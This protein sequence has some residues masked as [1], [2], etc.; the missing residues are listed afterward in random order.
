V[1]IKN[2]QVEAQRPWPDGMYVQG[3]GR[4]LVVVRA[5]GH[6]RT[7]FVEACPSSGGTFLRGEGPS[8][9]EAEDACWAKYQTVLNCADGLGVH[10]PF[11]AGRYESGAG[12]CT[13][14]GAWF[15]GMLEPSA[16]HQA[17]EL[18]AQTVAATWGEDI[19]VS[20][21]WCGLVA[22]ETARLLAVAADGTE[23]P[24]PTTVPPT[25]EEL[26]ELRAEEADL[27]VTPAA[28]AEVIEHLAAAAKHLDEA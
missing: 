21:W 20:R 3:G 16:R 8:V 11:D 17:R 14:C 4:G 26:A 2:T 27:E 28:I 23:P 1:L 13:R 24:A 19:I 22:D 10:G 6:Y 25:A 18:A 9:E 7:A 15:S 12:F 5:G